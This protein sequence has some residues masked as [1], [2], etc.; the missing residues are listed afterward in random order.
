MNYHAL[1]KQLK[2]QDESLP[3][4]SPSN[5]NQVPLHTLRELYSNLIESQK[6]AEATSLGIQASSLVDAP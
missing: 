2:R 4:S 6:L 3:T 5:L 1:T